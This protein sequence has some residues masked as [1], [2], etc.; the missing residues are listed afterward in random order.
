[1][2]PTPAPFGTACVSAPAQNAA[3]RDTILRASGNLVYIQPRSLGILHYI[4]DVASTIIL[5]TGSN[6]RGE[7]PNMGP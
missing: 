1:M 2:I 7:E 5:R 6:E 3:G 4:D